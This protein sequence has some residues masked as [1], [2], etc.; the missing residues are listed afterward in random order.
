MLFPLKQLW[1][2]LTLFLAG[3]DTN[4]ATLKFDHRI[5]DNSNNTIIHN[6]HDELTALIVEQGINPDDINITSS[7]KYRYSIVLKTPF[8]GGPDDDK[9]AVLKESLQA[10]IEDKNTVLEVTLTLRPDQI[11][12]ITSEEGD[13]IEALAQEYT[14]ALDADKPVILIYY[15]LHDGINAAFFRN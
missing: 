11:S 7:T 5:T 1:I 2:P 10:I 12:N 4:L 13:E 14:V 6:Y 15:G 3:C 9:I 8:P